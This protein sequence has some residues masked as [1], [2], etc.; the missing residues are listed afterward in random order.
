MAPERP[1]PEDKPGVA[2]VQRSGAVTIPVIPVF[3]L[4]NTLVHLKVL[5]VLCDVLY[6]HLLF[7]WSLH[8]IL[9]WTYEYSFNLVL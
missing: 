4:P 3:S 7:C 5:S 1:G 9:L 2:L 6:K 8:I